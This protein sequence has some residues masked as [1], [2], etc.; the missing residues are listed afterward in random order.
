MQRCQSWTRRQNAAEQ[1]RPV[2]AELRF[3]GEVGNRSW[4]PAS[5]VVRQAAQTF[6]SRPGSSAGRLKSGWLT[7]PMNLELTRTSAAGHFQS[8]RRPNACNFGLIEV[9]AD[10]SGES[11]DIVQGTYYTK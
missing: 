11:D 3:K 6:E 4:G 1:M 8:A 7:A 2:T 10:N 5:V 9:S